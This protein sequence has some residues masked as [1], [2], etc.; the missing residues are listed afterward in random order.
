MPTESSPA[1]AAFNPARER[2]VG[3]ACA[4]A[5]VAIW[6]GFSL[7][8]RFATH[9]ALTPWDVAALRYLGSFPLGLAL[10]AWTGWP[11]LPV[12]RSLG[13]MATAA[14]GFPLCAYAG[15]QLAPAA[16][17]VVFLTGTLPFMAALLGLL[18]LREPFP[19]RRWISL[20]IV[21]LGILLL[22][23]GSVE[24]APGA[25]RGDL[26][27][28]LGSL[29]W[30]GFTVML[31]LWQVPAAA[32]TVVLAVYP[33]LL[34]LPVWWLA[35]PSS[36]AAASTGAILHQLIYQGVLAMVVAG[37]LFARAVNALGSAQTTT[38]TAL[39]PAMVTLA[40]GPVLGE[41]LG[42]GGMLGALLV[43]L[44]MAFGVAAPWRRVPAVVDAPAPRG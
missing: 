34:Y 22:A 2:L 1:A 37:F 11:R 38:I 7:S 16:H 23:A 42:W 19:P 32:A 12:G 15:F 44:G 40:A 8:S 3:L 39:T 21:A 41:W 27:F 24:A 31:R 10:G 4:I 17:G 18:F 26:L 5:V 35:L 9:Q 28:L 13:L 25:W 33:P 29:S 36:M 6:T 43:S 30:A 14:F 20:G